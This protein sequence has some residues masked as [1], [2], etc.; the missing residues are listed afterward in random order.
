[1][2]LLS[3]AILLLINTS[4][5]LGM[6]VKG[7]FQLALGQALLDVQLQSEFRMWMVETP[8]LAFLFLTFFN[9]AFLLV[10]LAF[11]DVL[12]Y[13]LFVFAAPYLCMLSNG[14]S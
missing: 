5:M 1:M 10:H 2:I 9:C 8:C 12:H 7:N 4:F 6:L 13:L 3:H 11:S 14:V